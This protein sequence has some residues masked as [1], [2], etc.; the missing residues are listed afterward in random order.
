MQKVEAMRKKWTRE[1]IIRGILQ[2]EAEGLPLTVGEPGISQ[3]LYSAGSRVF[4]SWQNAIQ[5]A[6]LPSK[7]GKCGEKWP[8]SR[9][10]KLIR[11]LA[12]SNNP[13]S[14]KQ[15][16]YRYGSMRSAARRLFGSWSKAILAAGIDPTRFRRVVPWNRE[17]V[18]EGILTRA[19]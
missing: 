14:V 3:S 2:Y 16:E 17:L 13:L 1:R 7:L 12:R 6:G 4:G 10:L 19:L 9:I 11:S 15:L 18:I 5:A 8:P